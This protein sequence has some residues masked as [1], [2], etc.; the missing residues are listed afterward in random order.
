MIPLWKDEIWSNKV[1]GERVQ[2]EVRA[3]IGPMPRS[4]AQR[5]E[6]FEIKWW[7][8]IILLLISQFKD[9]ILMWTKLTDL[10][11]IAWTD[12]FYLTSILISLWFQHTAYEISTMSDTSLASHT[13]HRE[14]GSR[15]TTTI[16]LSPQQKLDVTNQI[17]AFS[18]SHSLSSS[19]Y[20]GTVFRCQYLIIY[21]YVQ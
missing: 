21:C 15:H 2:Q 14:E 9:G 4:L 17:H 7:F 5:S 8:T 3:E 12:I 1:K 18:R 13:L 11:C 20:Y 19:S 6:G 10:I 16:E